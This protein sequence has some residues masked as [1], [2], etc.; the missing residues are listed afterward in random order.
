MTVKI[1]KR[2]N[3]SVAAAMM[4]LLAL[5]WLTIS[6]PFVYQ[7]QQLVAAHETAAK[8]E[9][10]DNPLAG[11]NE[12]KSESGLGSLSEF[13]PEIPLPEAP[14]PSLLKWEKCHPSDLYFAFHPELLCPPPNPVC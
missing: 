2:Y 14:M 12:E 5:L 11:T 13:L 9:V 1:T 10:K 6:L 3:G 8:K 4:M 7:S